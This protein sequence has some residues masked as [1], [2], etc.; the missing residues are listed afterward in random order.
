MI[1]GSI[2]VT[3]DG[4]VTPR[5]AVGPSDAATDPNTPMP[6]GAGVI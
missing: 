2:I 5:K 1:D 6:E 4:A 3:G